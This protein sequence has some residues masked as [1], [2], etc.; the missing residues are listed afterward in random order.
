MEY[1]AATEADLPREFE[2]FVAAQEEL[3]TRHAVEWS[4][5][6][7]DR[8]AAI[9]RHLLEHDAERSFFAEE[10][11]RAAGFGAALVRD[12]AWYFSALFVAPEFQ[13]RGVGKE[14]LDLCWGDGYDRR[15]TITEAI[16]PVSTGMYARRG[17]VPVT[18]VLFFAG[19]PVVE[20][21]PGLARGK[22]DAEVLRR[23]DIA[24][25]GFDRS[26]D[27]PFW[28]SRPSAATVWLEG[29]GAVAYSYAS[30]SGGFIGPVAG[31]DDG[32]AAGALKAELARAEDNVMVFVP[33]TSP[34]CVQ[35]AFESGLRL[36]GPPGLL[37]L[38]P[39]ES[40][41]EGLVISSFF[42]L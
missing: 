42:L 38:S 39:P 21:P 28:A 24:A 13:G 5:P 36:A 10:D 2:I 15:L 23:L 37:L 14:L 30:T 4:P 40:P 9:R 1:R 11:G 32:R 20:M 33:G 29:D 27:H 34:A 8:F 7:Y 41:P 18:P 16:Q 19:R 6:P 26:V 17:L 25:Y 12:S 3:H 35:V 22:P 31:I